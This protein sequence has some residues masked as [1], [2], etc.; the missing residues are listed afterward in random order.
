MR[1]GFHI[2]YNYDFGK[3]G[4]IVSVAKREVD[5]LLITRRVV[6]AENTAKN[7]DE[8]MKVIYDVVDNIIALFDNRNT[9]V[10]DSCS[11]QFVYVGEGKYERKICVFCRGQFGYRVMQSVNIPLN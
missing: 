7:E 8:L 2:A 1:E 10:I 9:A 6:V 11:H 3:E 4:I 5:N